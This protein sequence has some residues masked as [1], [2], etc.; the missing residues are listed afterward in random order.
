MGDSPAK[1]LRH[2]LK[3]VADAEDRETK[4][5]QRRIKLRSTVGVDAGRPTGKH[6]RQWITGLDLLDR[7][8]VR[9][10][11]GKDPRFP[12]PPGDQ[13]RVLRTEVDHQYRPV[14]RSGFFE[15]SRFGHGSESNRVKTPRAAPRR[16]AGCRRS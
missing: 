13:L 4:V 7:G 15:V 16:H 8:G 11:L 6:D 2:G 3:P 5:E 10:D 14:S 1:R 9:D 12:H